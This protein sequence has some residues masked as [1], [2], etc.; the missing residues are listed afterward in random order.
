M[1]F[2][3]PI[4]GWLVASVSEDQGS[5]TTMVAVG[6]QVVIPVFWLFLEGG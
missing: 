1:F 6:G 2:G 3:L 4:G 5:S